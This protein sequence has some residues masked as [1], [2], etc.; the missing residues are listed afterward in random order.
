MTLGPLREGVFKSV[1][2]GKF[3]ERVSGDNNIVIG[4]EYDIHL[5]FISFQVIMCPSSI[6]DV[7][8]FKQRRGKSR[9]LFGISVP[10][11]PAVSHA[12]AS[13]SSIVSR[14]PT[15]MQ[16]CHL[17]VKCESL[18]SSQS[19]FHRWTMETRSRDV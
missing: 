4:S 11:Q 6:T 2:V 10:A 5:A 13:K 19:D 16:T 15:G 18:P 17:S 12:K 8:H 14:T 7:S 9:H 1:K 3:H